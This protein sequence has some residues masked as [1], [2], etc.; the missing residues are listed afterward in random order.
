M[1][2]LVKTNMRLGAGIR[3]TSWFYITFIENNGMAYGMSFICKPLLTLF[4]VAAVAVIGYYMYKVVRRGNYNAGYVVCLAMIIA[5]AAGNIFDCLFYGQIFTVSTTWFVSELVPFGEGYAPLLQGRVVDMFYFPII[6]TTL[7]DW[8]PHFG[9]QHFVFFSPVFNF[10][11]ACIS[12]GVVLV[13]IFYRRQ[14][15]NISAVLAR[16]TRREDKENEEKK[17]EPQN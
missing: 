14:L 2:I 7:P 8:L 6:N 13:I 17:E 5:G 4:R 3:I 1:K 9:G 12:V 11:D 10:A 16:T 15:E